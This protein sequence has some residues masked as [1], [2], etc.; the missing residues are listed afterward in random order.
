M[1][2]LQLNKYYAPFVGGVETV[3]RQLAQGLAQTGHHVHVATCH[4]SF[5][6]RTTFETDGS[7]GVSRAG[8]FG[9]VANAALAPRFFEV[10]H[11]GVAWADV[12]HFHVPSPLAEL[13][14][15]CFGV[16]NDTSVVTTFHADPASTRWKAL[17]PVYNLVLHPLLRR[18]DRIVV[19]AP[20]NARDTDVL[21]NVETRRDVI[22]LGTEYSPNPP[23][24]EEKRTL[25]QEHLGVDPDTPV[26][27]FVGRLA[28]YKG[29]PQ[30]I[31]AMREVPG[32]LIVI[33]TGE[34]EDKLKALV[35]SHNLNNVRF[36]GYVTDDL[37]P[38][39]YRSADVFA[40]PSVSPSEAFGIVQLDAMAHGLP[41]VNTNLPTGVPFVSQS[42]KTGL[43]VP[44]SDTSALAQAL[45]RILDDG[46][47]RAKLSSQAVRRAS[48]FTVGHM[49]QRYS[50]LLSNVL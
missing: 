29:L 38:R 49:V 40:F 2:V 21:S 46:A 20:E 25:K 24:D 16:P 15:L 8:S 43:T 28:Y 32:V 18:A 48:D 44:P 7:V 4:H 6:P 50:E 12:V 35:N 23:S 1:K 39:Y 31:D 27:L 19:T 34:Q 37:L 10:F 30:L 14:H 17:A 5:H 33:G 13:A 22:P 41:V 45:C 36:E 11:R 3:V 47:F 9:S 26:T 42:G